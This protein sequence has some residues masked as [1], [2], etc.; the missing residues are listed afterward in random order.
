[1]LLVSLSCWLL[2]PSAR[3][4]AFDR[5]TNPIL[6]KVPEAKGVK[7][8]KQLS[9]ELLS[10]HDR[11]LQGISGALVVVKTNE[12]RF[13]KLLVQPARHK[14]DAEKSLPM[15]LID[16]Y[17]TYREAEERTVRASGRNLYLFPGFRFSVDL[18]QVVPE[19]LSADLKLVVKGDDAVIEPVGKARI[20]LVTQALPEAAPKKTDKLVVGET[21]HPRYFNGTYQLHDDGRRSGMLTL[22]VEE[23]GQISGSYFSDKDGQKYEIY[24]KLESP[25]HRIQFT[26]KFPRTE[27]V[28]QGWLFTGDGKYLTGSSRM[29]DREAG[30]YAVRVEE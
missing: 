4:D 21:F 14:V 22:K 20:F 17:I 2:T 23:K 16:R 1:M 6:A 29:L 18:G 19:E 9:M 15:L 7:E 13:G 12:G 27:Q 10:D 24:G 30:F 26:I 25:S 3:A 5:Y 8:V 28:F 11:V